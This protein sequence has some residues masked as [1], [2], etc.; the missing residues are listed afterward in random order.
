MSCHIFAATNPALR[1]QEQ[2]KQEA[3]IVNTLKETVESDIKSLERVVKMA[4]EGSSAAKAII[5]ERFSPSLKTYSGEALPYADDDATT[6]AQRIAFIFC[7]RFPM[8]HAQGTLAGEAEY[9]AE[10]AAW[11]NVVETMAA[12][13]SLPDFI[14]QAAKDEEER[15]RRHTVL[16]QTTGMPKPGEWG[17]G[18]AAA[19][20]MEAYLTK[21]AIEVA[22]KKVRDAEVEKRRA[23]AHAK[24]KAYGAMAA[25]A[26]RAREEGRINAEVQRRLKAAQEE[27]EIQ[28]RLQAALASEETLG[29]RVAQR[30]NELSALF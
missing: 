15:Y 9:Q 17:C 6:K 7:Q 19:A 8:G 12:N 29:M 30:A 14:A 11:R 28:R 16:G 27:A 23:Q 1:A 13:P 26:R 2:R 10:R 24:Q 20:L 21:T 5:R 18:P 22:E 25:G 4:Q 3:A